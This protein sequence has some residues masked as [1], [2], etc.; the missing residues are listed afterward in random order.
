MFWK[1]V[2]IWKILPIMAASWAWVVSPSSVM[3]NAR[4]PFSGA[5]SGE[6]D[7]VAEA[8]RAAFQAASTASRTWTVLIRRSLP[9][10]HFISSPRD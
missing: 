3:L 7:G 4:P 2:S 8:Q 10:S 5:I 9:Q 6:F 1:P